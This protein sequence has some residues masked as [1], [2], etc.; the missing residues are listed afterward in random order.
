M[1]WKAPLAAIVLVGIITSA[2][3]Q[4]TAPMQAPGYSNGTPVTASA[5]G[6]TG[7]T[8]ATIPA[9]P[10]RTAYLCGFSIRATATTGIAG[11]ATVTGTISGTLN[12]LQATGAAPVV[13]ITEP[14]LGSICIAASAP[15]QAIAVVSAAP[16][17][18]G[19]I[20]VSAWGFYGF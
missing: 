17:T 20:T 15:N 5:T 3:A 7:V 16:G 13:G 11:T 19:V 2:Y 10:S 14:H 6:T 4:F 18:A 12:F 9:V 1:M 8:T